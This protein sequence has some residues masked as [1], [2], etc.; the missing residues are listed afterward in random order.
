M[1]TAAWDPVLPPALAQGM[2]DLIDDLEIHEI[3]E[4]GH[5]TQQERPDELNR[6]LIDWLSRKPL[7]GSGAPRR[8]S[9]S[10]DTMCPRLR[11]WSWG[12]RSG[13]EGDL[14]DLADVVDQV[15]VQLGE[16][17]LGHV[18]EVRLVLA[19]HDH[20]GEARPGGRRAASA[21]APP[22]GSTLPC[23]VTSPVMPTAGSPGDR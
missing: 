10:E 15:H 18:V 3:A 6:I 1:V 4:C 16:H 9:R 19:R 14:E 13:G 12:G 2:P 22:I 5:W 7:S 17:G 21:S 20:V 8:N 11:Q 23:S